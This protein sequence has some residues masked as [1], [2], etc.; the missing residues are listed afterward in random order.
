MKPYIFEYETSLYGVDDFARIMIVTA[1]NEAEIYSY[2]KDTGKEV[3]FKDLPY[4]DQEKINHAVNEHF[5][6]ESA[7]NWWRDHNASHE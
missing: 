3:L 5:F 1:E 6:M 7:C 2:D 4:K